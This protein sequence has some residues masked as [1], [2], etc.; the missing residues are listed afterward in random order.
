MTLAEGPTVASVAAQLEQSPHYLRIKKLLIFA[1]TGTWETQPER[2]AAIDLRDLLARTLEV[3]PTMRQLRPTLEN[4]VRSLNKPV[5]YLPV[6]ETILRSIAVLYPDE[7]PTEWFRTQTLRPQ[8]AILPPQEWFD[9]RLELVNRTNPLRL[10]ILIAAA[11][12]QGDVTQTDPLLVKW[13]ELERLL[14]DLLLACASHE[15]LCQRLHTVAGQLDEPEEYQ[16]VVGTLQEVLAPIYQRLRQQATVADVAAMPVAVVAG[17]APELS[18]PGATAVANPEVARVSDPVQQHVQ[19]LSREAELQR[20]VAT[21]VQ[22]VIGE[23]E[24]AFRTL[25]GHLETATGDVP[26]ATRYRYLR[27]FVM[28]V[29]A[30]ADRFADILNRW[31]QGGG[32]L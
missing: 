11:L 29:Q 9:L 12:R 17:P 14:A 31:E 24:Q 20:L 22:R 25:E 13:L 2:L 4:L 8:T 3:H 28:Q 32:C 16:Q 18:P 26:P 10:K 7:D 6:A 19:E 21:A 1:C 27:E 5:E 23:I 15:E 30:M